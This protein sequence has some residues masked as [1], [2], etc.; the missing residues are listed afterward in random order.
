MKNQIK[1]IVLL[2][3]VLLTAGHVSAYDFGVDG[4]Y[5]NVVS[6]PDLTAEITYESSNTPYSFAKF[7]IPAK[8]TF[9]GRTFTIVKIGERAFKNCRNL[10]SV[11]IPESVN[12][13]GNSAFY[14]CSSFV[15]VTIPES[16]NEIGDS[17][18]YGCSSLVSITIPENVNKIRGYAFFGCSSLSSIAIPESVKGIGACAFRSCT[19]LDS[20]T[21]HSKTLDPL[22]RSSEWIV[23]SNCKNVKYVHISKNVDNIGDYIFNLTGCCLKEV[24]ID[25]SENPLVLGC[26]VYY[27]YGG[28]HGCFLSKSLEKI[29]LGR[30][31][32]RLGLEFA[33][34]KEIYI[35]DYVT[36]ING[37]SLSDHEAL[38]KITIGKGLSEVPNLS[39]Y[40]KLTSLILSSEVPQ[41]AL[42]SNFSNAQYL[43]LNVYVPKGSLAAY[44]SADVWKNFWNL[45]EMETT[46]INN[47]CFSSNDQ[48]VKESKY[49][50]ATGREIKSVHKGLNIIK[51]SD[52]TTRKVIIK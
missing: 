11:T 20:I 1:K 12:E 25:D 21:I 39:T 48:S 4:I 3:V 18:F 31:I 47:V 34:V 29:Y 13:I 30:N 45:Q 36:S 44:Q 16:V 28:R 38:E 22:D 9:M 23:F 7:S 35:G 24:I 52:G 17:T 32:N 2:A 46:D 14:G 37:L 8:V 26:G 49:F 33:S 51:M 42:E 43:S 50:D 15:S 40:S 27:S 10:T 5:Y 6:L 41:K 19:S